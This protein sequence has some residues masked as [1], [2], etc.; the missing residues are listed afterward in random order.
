MFQLTLVVMALSLGLALVLACLYYGVLTYQSNSNKG[1]LQQYG[2]SGDQIISA[3]TLYQKDYGMAPI[4]TPSSIINQLAGTDD[5]GNTYLGQL[6]SGNWY[7]NGQGE[8]R[9]RRQRQY[10]L[11]RR[12]RRQPHH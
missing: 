1:T 12:R 4:G 9:R 8:C 6:P 3:I 7:I 11:H 10:D 2:S 5:N